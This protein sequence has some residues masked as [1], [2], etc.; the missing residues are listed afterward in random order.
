MV[1]WVM[2]PEDVNVLIPGNC[3]YVVLLDGKRDFANVIELRILR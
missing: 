1:S 2:T 3:E